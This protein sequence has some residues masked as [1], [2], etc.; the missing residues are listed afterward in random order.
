MASIE[1]NGAPNKYT[2]GVIGDI[3]TDLISGIQYELIAIYISQTYKGD[4]ATYDWKEIKQQTPGD[5]P[6]IVDN[7]VTAG[8]NNPVSSKAVKSYVDTNV[9]A[10]VEQQVE[11]QIETKMQESIQ[12]TVDQA[13]ANAIGGSGEGD[14]EASDEIDSWF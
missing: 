14:S 11:Q 1:R 4:E 2:E 8:S 5:G 13:V 3:Y 7:V 6:I 10:I 9:V 12:E